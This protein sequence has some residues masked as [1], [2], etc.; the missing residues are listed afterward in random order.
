MRFTKQ[1]IVTLLEKY[2]RAYYNKSLSGKSKQNFLK[3]IQAESFQKASIEELSV[4]FEFLQNKY[5]F[6]TKTGDKTWEF[7]EMTHKVIQFA[8]NDYL[9]KYSPKVVLSPII[10]AKKRP[11][12][13]VIE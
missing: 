2:G 13:A 12:E 11:N 1:D 10:K 3:M 7:F 5:N 6:C 9:P 8:T 4:K